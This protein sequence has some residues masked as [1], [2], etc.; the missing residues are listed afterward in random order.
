MNG[1]IV[2]NLIVSGTIYT[3]NQFAAGVVSNPSGNTTIT[4]CRSSITIISSKSGE[5]SHGGFVGVFSSGTTTITGCVFDGSLLTTNGTTNCGGFVGWADN[6]VANLIMEDN[7]FAPT[8]VN[9]ADGCKTFSRATYLNYISFTANNYYTTTLG[10]AQGKQMHSIT[11]DENVTVAFAGDLT[12]YDVSGISTNGTGL[13]YNDV[14][15]AGNVDEVSLTLNYNDGVEYMTFDGYSASAGTLTGSDSEYILVMPD[16]DVTIS[17]NIL[18]ITKFIRGYGESNGGYFLIASPVGTV[19]PTNVANMLSNNYD[20]YA[21][22]QSPEDGM[23]WRNYKANTFDLEP[24]MGYLYANSEDVTLVFPGMPYTGS[25][26][27]TL[28]RTDD[29]GVDF[30]GWNL[31][32]NPFTETV[33]IADNRPFYTMNADGTEIITSTSNSIEAMEGVFVVA[34]TDGE[35]MTFTTTAPESNGKGL[36]LN[37]RQGGVSAFGQVQG[38]TTS[39]SMAAVVDRAV[40]RFGEGGMLPKFQLNRNSTK[41]YIP[42][43]GEDYAVVNAE[44]AGELP[45]NFKAKENG[46]Y[47]LSLSTEDVTFDY[48]QIIDMTG[49]IVLSGDAINRVSTNGMT[50]VVYVLR[51][52][53]G[54]DEKT[55]KFVVQ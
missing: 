7:L 39:G 40:V 27:V 6:Y 45:V 47:T 33:Y 25:G 37:I 42:M 49:R 35:R 12:N 34:N 11:G 28:S 50:P 17:A 4:N 31:V 1:A 22:D 10:D 52:V 54:N 41:V 21:F 2:K 19:S 43:D 5:G 18:G 32:G 51:L 9:M 30:Q 38:S 26:E 24:G 14:L 16:E 8:S 48:L 15:Y 46:S 36:V 55:Q 20:L 13:M 23:E 53:N 44:R 3:A 29:A